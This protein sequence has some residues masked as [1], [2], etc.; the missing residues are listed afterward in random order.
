MVRP[1]SGD[2]EYSSPQNTT[3][4]LLWITIRSP[5]PCRHALARVLAAN[6]V[7]PRGVTDVCGGLVVS[8]SRL[9][10]RPFRVHPPPYS[11][12]W[13]QPPSLRGL[14]LDI[15]PRGGLARAGHDDGG[16]HLGAL[17]CL[18]G[19]RPGRDGDEP[20]P[21]RV[22]RVGRRRSVGHPEGV[23][24]G[25]LRV[26]PRE[27]DTAPPRRRRDGGLV[28]DSVAD[29]AVVAGV[30]SPDPDCST[31]KTTRP[32]R[33][34]TEAARPQST[35]GFASGDVGAGAE[36]G[37][38]CVPCVLAARRTV[39][40]SAESL[41]SGAVWLR[42][43]SVTAAGRTGAAAAGTLGLGI[44]AGDHRWPPASERRRVRSSSSP[45]RPVGEPWVWL[46]SVV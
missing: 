7:R 37:S 20:G 16:T 32:T 36:A 39:A 14:A 2:T 42:T 46:T 25:G 43:G 3:V 41:P 18:D 4:T 45:P 23:L 35:A 8:A 26:V 34:T 31:R 21:L 6:D 1:V 38:A 44:G 15:G 40:S 17:R 30:G 5:N 33:T 13:C 10:V 22:P 19:V 29:R 28:E 9:P 11:G 12:S 24:R 27:T